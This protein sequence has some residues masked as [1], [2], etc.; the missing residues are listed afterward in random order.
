MSCALNTSSQP[1]DDFVLHVEEVRERF[2]EPLC[3][4]MTAAFGVDELNVDAHAISSALNA[5]LQHIADVQVAPDLLQI[6]R[7]AFVSEGG[8]SADDERPAYT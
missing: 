2:V 1:R 3:P 6:D 7:L 8:V 5:A 4:K